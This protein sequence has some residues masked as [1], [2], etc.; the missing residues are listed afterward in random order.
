[1]IHRSLK[2]LSVLVESCQPSL[3]DAKERKETVLISILVKDMSMCLSACFWSSHKTQ[4]SGEDQV[5]V[6]PQRKVKRGKGET[7]VEM[8]CHCV[9]PS[10]VRDSPGLGVVNH[11]S[12]CLA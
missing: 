2:Y 12:S 6:N 9:S 4:M 11:L 1:M 5:P 7:N 3:C 8:E 10:L